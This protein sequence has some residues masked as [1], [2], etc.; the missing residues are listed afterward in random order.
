MRISATCSWAGTPTNSRSNL[1]STTAAMMV[2]LQQK[3]GIG[4]GGFNFDAKCR[5]GSNDVMDLFYAHI[6]GMDAFARGL[7]VAD[8]ILSDKAFN[9]I[10]EDRYA[11]WKTPMGKKILSGKAT[12]I[13]SRTTSSRPASRCSRVAAR[14]CWRSISTICLTVT[15]HAAVSWTGQQH[16]GAEGPYH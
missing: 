5:R 6:G 11:S 2:V 4:S 15:I 16:A 13:H 10:V 1:Y 7:L 14:N 12:L 9:K 8:K 3:G